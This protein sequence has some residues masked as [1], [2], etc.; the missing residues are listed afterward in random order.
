MTELNTEYIGDTSIV[1]EEG[2]CKSSMG[3]TWPKPLYFFE[4]DIGGFDRAVWRFEK[5]FN[6]LRLKASDDIPADC[7]DKYDIVSKP[8]PVPLDITKLMGQI[9]E[10]KRTEAKFTVRFPKKV[11]GMKELWQSIVTDFVQL[12]QM[13]KVK[14]FQLDTATLLYN[15]S[16]KTILQELQERQLYNWKSNGNKMLFDENSFRERLQPTEYGFAY[17]K[18]RQLY[19]TAQAYR[20]NTVSVHYPT[21]EYIKVT[22]ASGQ[23]KD[24]KSGLKKP[25]GW[26]E[27]N[28]IASLIV[29]TSVKEVNMGGQKLKIPM[30]KVTKCGIS[31]MG[32]DAVG[33]EL[34]ASFESIMQERDRMRGVA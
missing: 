24:E 20:K 29:W 33:K 17:D 14:T 25:D 28:K 4:F 1:G 19:Q 12:V 31:Q 30:C 6:V 13:S 32:L 9:T 34:T 7:F 11:E 2:S 27:L 18:L 21:D 15:I 16:H 3:L 22:D 8:Y 26:N 5:E 10:G 23:S